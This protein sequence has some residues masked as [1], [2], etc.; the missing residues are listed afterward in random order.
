LGGGEGVTVKRDKLDILFSK[1]IRERSDYSCDRCH[2]NFRHETHGLQCSHFVTRGHHTLRWEPLNAAAHCISCHFKLGAD[3][4]LFAEWICEY[5][6][7]EK[8]EALKLKKQTLIKR[9]KADKEALY[10]VMK[11]EEKRMTALRH[12][13]KTGRIEFSLD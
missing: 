6:G 1:L 12:G 2:L 11:A 7:H 13:G 3:P 10:R 8:Y 9:S 5:L 4:V